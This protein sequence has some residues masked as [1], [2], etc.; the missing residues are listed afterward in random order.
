MKNIIFAALA[1]G[2]IF[3]VVTGSSADKPKSAAGEK[4]GDEQAAKSDETALQGTWKGRSV[5]DNPEHQVTFVISGTHFEFR[6]ETETNNWYKGTFTLKQDAAPRQFIATITECPFSQYVGKISMAIYK[7]EKGTLTITA[8][9]PGKEGV[10]EDF[11]A[12]NAACIE[13]KK[14]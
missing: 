9:E 4:A 10:P 3:F 5:T 1:A 11:D 13:V 2:A 12:E 8:H 6:D 14:K 7:I